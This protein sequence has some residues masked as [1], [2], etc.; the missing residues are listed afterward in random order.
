MG[1]LDFLIGDDGGRGSANAANEARFQEILSII[2]GLQFDQKTAAGEARGLLDER[3]GNF[4][5]TFDLARANVE[6]SGRS[7]RRAINETSQKV[8]AGSDVSFDR[9]GLSDSSVKR[10]SRNQVAANT[11]RA[12]GDSYVNEGNLIS[13]LLQRQ[14]AGA[15]Q[16]EGDIAGFVTN[17]SDASTNLG[18]A[19]SQF[20]ADRQDIAG[21]PSGGL[22]GDL[23]G[24][25]PGALIGLI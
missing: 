19:L 7:A 4:N 14:A 11:G 1:F 23:L 17:R 8:A 21:E 10:Q 18:L 3:L 9:R 20:Y 6:G 13:S 12:I 24:S 15:S 25:L 22:F 2:R 16:L 5:Q